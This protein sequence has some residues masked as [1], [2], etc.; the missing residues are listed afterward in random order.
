MWSAKEIWDAGREALAARDN[1]AP[2]P[3]PAPAPVVEAAPAPAVEADFDPAAFGFEA[4]PYRVTFRGGTSGEYDGAVLA[5]QFPFDPRDVK[6]V[7]PVEEVG[8]GL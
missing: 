2:A 3:A 7:E 5:R 8:Q 1:P 4:R 6:R